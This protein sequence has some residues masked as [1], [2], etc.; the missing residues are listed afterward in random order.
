MTWPC[1]PHSAT[2]LIGTKKVKSIVLCNILWRSQDETLIQCL[3]S[4]LIGMWRLWGRSSC[5]VPKYCKNCCENKV[6]KNTVSLGIAV[7]CFITEFLFAEL[8]LMKAGYLRHIGS[9]VTTRN[10]T[11]MSCNILSPLMQLFLLDKLLFLVL[12]VCPSTNMCLCCNTAVF[13]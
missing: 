5:T 8:K 12:L 6:C 3:V 1:R 7:S 13:L 9:M 4:Y 2:R 11:A 10:V